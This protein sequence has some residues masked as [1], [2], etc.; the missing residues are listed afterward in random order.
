MDTARF[1]LKRIRLK[2]FFP[3]R[4]DYDVHTTSESTCSKFRVF[5]WNSKLRRRLNCFNQRII[6]QPLLTSNLTSPTDVLKTKVFDSDL[7]GREKRSL[8]VVFH[9]KIFIIVTIACVLQLFSLL[10]SSKRNELVY[11]LSTYLRGRDCFDRQ[12]SEWAR[13]KKV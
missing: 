6:F 7:I 10:Q 13:A 12:M 11:L 5:R 1:G 9:C 2:Y 8:K 3:C 4:A